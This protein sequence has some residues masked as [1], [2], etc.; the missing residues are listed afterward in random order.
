MHRSALSGVGRGHQLF[1]NGKGLDVLGGR[2]GLGELQGTRLAGV[3][4]DGGRFLCQSLARE[5]LASYGQPELFNI[6]QGSQ[7]TS[8][9]FSAVLKAHGIEISLDGRRR[10]YDNIFV[11]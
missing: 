4:Y 10:C 2:H 9:S 5:T 6:D 11:E 7:F 8:E 1:A 3:E